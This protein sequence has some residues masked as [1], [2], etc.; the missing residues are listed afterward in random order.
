MHSTAAALLLNSNLP[1][2]AR[3]AHIYP[4]LAY[5]SLLSVGQMCDSGFAAVFTKNNVQVVHEK[6]VTIKGPAYLT[7][8]RN[9][10]SNHLWVTDISGNHKTSAEMFNKNKI[11]RV[12][13]VF[14][15]RTIPDIITY[16][17]QSLWNPTVKAWTRAI[18][19]GYFST[20]PGLTS[21]AVRKHLRPSIA[22]AKGHMTKE[23][24]NIRS[25]KE[26]HQI[27]TEEPNNKKG[28]ART[29]IA[30]FK[31]VDFEKETGIIAT[32]QT[33]RFPIRASSGNQYLMVVHVR[34]PNVILAIP[35]KNRS[36]T[37]LLQAY[38]M[39]YDRITSKG[40][41]PTLHICD[42][43]CPSIFKKILELKHVNLQKVP[44]YDHRTNPAESAINTFKSHFIAG[45]AN[46]PPNFPL[47]LW[48]RLIPHAE[49]SLNLLRDSNT[50]PHLSAHSHWEGVYDYNAHPLAP[51]GCKI[52]VHETLEQ[53][54]TWDEKG[55]EGWYIGPSMEHYRCHRVYLP[56]TR[57][58][59]IGKSVRFF[60]HNCVAPE[61]DPRDEATRAAQL[62][63]AALEK[64]Q[65]GGPYSP[66]TQQQLQALTQL[67][68]IFQSLTDHGQS[69]NSIKTTACEPRAVSTDPRRNGP[70]KN[71]VK[72]PR[73]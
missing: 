68:E 27:M 32:D 48:D 19:K 63:T 30:T 1:R 33:G 58:E 67:S 36:Q 5:K 39:L 23:R 55:K 34:D 50:H 3:Q 57:S 52:V 60:P 61:V 51:P 7:G 25:T 17:H 54:G 64:A 9:Q 53:R 12:N 6:D 21:Q 38:E 71:Y 47:H 56:Q 4:S 16:H 31:T 73:V 40:F 42:N 24:Q 62:L 11:P 8:T 15:M 2:E 41:K 72:Q 70:Q 49:L 28:E 26:R 43:E 10:Q 18:D 22:T 59:R 44:P 29:N 35:I 46:L 45:L 69:T 20:F 13:N 66:P 37:S 14:K 65:K